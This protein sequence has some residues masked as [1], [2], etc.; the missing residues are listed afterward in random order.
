MY[1]RTGYILCLTAIYSQ[2]TYSGIT[3]HTSCKLKGTAIYC[4]QVA[5][6]VS[7]TLHCQVCFTCCDDHMFIP[8]CYSR[9][10]LNTLLQH[11]L[12]RLRYRTG[13]LCDPVNSLLKSVICSSYCLTVCWIDHMNRKAFVYLG[14]RLSVI[15]CICCCIVL[16]NI[17]HCISRCILSTVCALC[18]TRYCRILCGLGGSVCLSRCL[19]NCGICLGCRICC[20]CI[21][22][23]R[24]CLGCISCGLSVCGIRSS[25]SLCR[26][27]C[28]YC[29]FIYGYSC[30][31]ICC[32]SSVGNSAYR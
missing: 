26:G 20:L 17:Q 23:C 21:G 9:I 15:G 11:D 28:C 7:G 18:I 8:N 6:I 22:S 12:G 24:I 16:C 27:L 30:C 3:L 29:S 31:A 2:L 25:L 19:S 1:Q 5:C 10:D 32:K 14:L 13:T 4:K